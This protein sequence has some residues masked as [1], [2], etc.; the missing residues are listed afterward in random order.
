MTWKM[1]VKKIE[2]ALEDGKFVGIRYHREEL[3]N[4]KNACGID[5]VESYDW[6]GKQFKTIITYWGKIEEGDVVIDK[7][8]VD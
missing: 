7:V 6:N 1:A 4:D 3:E 2:K 8:I 5:R